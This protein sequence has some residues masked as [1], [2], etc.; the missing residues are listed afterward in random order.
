[1]AML[2]RRSTSLR[3]NA[4]VASLVAGAGWVGCSAPEGNGAPDSDTADIGTVDAGDGDIGG[5]D[6]GDSGSGG[7]GT[8]P[9][10]SKYCDSGE[11]KF[12]PR[13]P[14]VFILVD[15]SGSIFDL[16]QWTP[17]RD[18]V[19]PVVKILEPD[20][21]IGLG[22]YNSVNGACSDVI[23][24]QGT[25]ALNN[26]AAI[27]TF[28]K[29]LSATK[30]GGKLDTPTSVAVQQAAAILTA[31]DGPGA[32]AILLVTADDDPDFCDDVGPDC[33]NDAAI[34]A[35]QSAYAQGIQTF[36]F[37]IDNPDIQHA[38]WLDFWAQGGAGE[39]PNWITGLT[40][41]TYSGAV[42]NACQ[43]NAGWKSAWTAAGRTG[44]DPIGAYAA[45]EGSAKAFLSDDPNEIAEAIK[46]KAQ[47]LKSCKQD[48]SSPDFAGV[49]DGAAGD[50]YLNDEKEP[51]PSGEWRMNSAT[52]LELLGASCIKWL[53]PG[54]VDLFAGFACDELVVK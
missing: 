39:S 27:E 22:A 18:K 45:A 32:K 14:T 10:K 28:Y 42:Y 11:V 30:P 15:R 25:I 51:I 4:V 7:T 1:M 23:E 37:A 6:V 46:G 43:G 13:I 8:G 21:R 26:F 48:L 17:L 47:G 41:D 29:G 5:V 3:V 16:Q 31:D 49:K 54:V 20:V 52:E 9:D 44:F 36:V 12:E 34:G 53:E 24:D 33:G 35:M 19:L 38:D 2:M 40:K 50:I